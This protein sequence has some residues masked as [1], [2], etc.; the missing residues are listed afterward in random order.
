MTQFEAITQ[1]YIISST[2]DLR[3]TI[4][5]VSD[6][7][8]DISGYS[9]DELIGKP[10]SIIRHEDTP[11]EIFDELWRVLKSG[12]KWSGIIKNKSKDGKEYWVDSYIE[13]LIT[14]SKITGYISLRID[15]TDTFKLENSNTKL[16]VSVRNF[17]KLFDS[18]NL[19]IAI[20]DSFGN[21]KDVNEY[22]CK[23][24]GYTK[25]EFL[26]NNLLKN[27]DESYR[28]MDL[29]HKMYNDFEPINLTEEKECTT[30]LGKKI[31]IKT[32]YKYYCEDKILITVK[33][34]S[35]DKELSETSKL[36]QRQA[37]D[38]ALG[39]MLSMIAHQ[40]RQPLST[41]STII[42]KIN[43]KRE[44][45][46]YNGKDLTEDTAKIKKMT[47][48]LSNTIDFFRN[49]SK[50]K[51]GQ[52]VS[53]KELVEIV[54]CITSPL[55]NES[56]IPLSFKYEKMENQSIDERLDQVL[57]NLI[58]NSIDAYNEKNLSGK[59]EVIFT[60]IE[61]VLRITVSDKA[62]GIS[63]DVLNKILDPY[64]STKSKNGTGL[65]LYMC[66]NIVTGSLD[67]ELKYENFNGGLRFQIDLPK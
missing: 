1:K 50:P 27:H 40:W 49:Y 47:S 25:Q 17:E 36:L 43:V 41:I 21:Y 57:I 6:A 63:D 45:K 55:C 37:K 48:H 31:W 16:L 54:E 20:V 32:Q 60:N 18:I 22:L 8:C 53:I 67:G 62:G 11:V 42:S 61:S 3:G 34:I 12:N 52:K 26:S 65:G 19:G 30:R 24:M 58:K 10:H 2:T 46:M 35:A 64:F 15:V 5:D 66:K 29:F 38:A 56:A 44:M 4:T 13:P 33:N 51:E 59:I 7:F 14:N 28:I 23:L 39:E 9:K